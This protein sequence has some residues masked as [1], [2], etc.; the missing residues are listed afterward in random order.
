M[1]ALIQRVS[2]ASVE[3]EGKIVGRSGPGLLVLLGVGQGDGEDEAM[4]LADKTVGLRIFSD[5]AG[6]FNHSLLDVGGS[7]LVVSQFTLYADL[8]RGRRPGFSQAALPEV[9]APLV[10][11]YV[12][13]IRARG[14]TVETGVFGAMMRVALVNEGPVTIML[15]SETFNRSRRDMS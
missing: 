3:V 9:A 6:R 8:Q 5:E 4:L 7:V 2:T 13:A 12:T 11:R 1:R 15:D 10:E 14:I